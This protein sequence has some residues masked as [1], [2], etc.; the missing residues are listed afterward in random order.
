LRFETKKRQLRE[1]ASD[2]GYRDFRE[3]SESLDWKTDHVEAQNSESSVD[4]EVLKQTNP[5]ANVK[6]NDKKKNYKSK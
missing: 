3:T 4:L 2:H 1:G 5:D 6:K